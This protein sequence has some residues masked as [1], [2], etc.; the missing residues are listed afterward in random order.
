MKQQHKRSHGVQQ[1]FE[2][3]IIAIKYLL[4]LRAF[5]INYIISSSSYISKKISSDKMHMCG[6]FYAFRTEINRH[7]C[8]IGTP[9]LLC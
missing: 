3:F 9:H 7:Y 6:S 5:H 1:I 4:F 8:E 2:T